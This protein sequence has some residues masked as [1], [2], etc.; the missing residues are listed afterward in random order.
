MKQT[1]NEKM[2][3]SVRGSVAG[4]EKT[5]AGGWQGGDPC[6]GETFGKTMTCGHLECTRGKEV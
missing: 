5:N 1:K 3:R 2:W 4:S 6:S